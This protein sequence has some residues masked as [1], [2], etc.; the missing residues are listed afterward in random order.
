MVLD[1]LT[2]HVLSQEQSLKLYGTSPNKFGLLSTFTAVLNADLLTDPHKTMQCLSVF[3]WYEMCLR[4]NPLQISL[5]LTYNSPQYSKPMNLR[6]LFTIQR[7]RPTRS[8]LYLSLSRHSFTTHLNFFNRGTS[9]TAP[10]L[11]NDRAP[12]FRSFSIPP[13]SLPLTLHHL[14]LCFLLTTLWKPL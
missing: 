12:E 11:W 14:D 4:V 6:K 3:F 2:I 13:P 7:T 5:S 8:S 9:R 10:R 1:V